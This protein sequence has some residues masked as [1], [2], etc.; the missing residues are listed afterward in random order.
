MKIKLVQNEI[1]IFDLSKMFKTMNI[2]F[3]QCN[4][5]VGI[6]FHIA[7]LKKGKC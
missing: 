6:G 2:P 7:S 4:S 3:K 5:V 1:F